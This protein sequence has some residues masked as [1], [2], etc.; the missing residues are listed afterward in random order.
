M[1]D[2]D[3]TDA[4]FTE[5]PPT[6]LAGGSDGVMVLLFDI[7]RMTR[8]SQE[9][10]LLASSESKTEIWLSTPADVDEVLRSKLL[11]TIHLFSCTPNLSIVQ[12]MPGAV[13]CVHTVLWI[14][15]DDGCGANS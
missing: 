14:S 13:S 7:P 1:W 8:F 9:G 12:E 4:T 3:A 6:K 5:A 2:R 11:H 10:N 15:L